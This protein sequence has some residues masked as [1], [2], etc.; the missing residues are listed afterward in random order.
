MPGWI[1]RR[2]ALALL[3]ALLAIVVLLSSGIGAVAI[4]AGTV[5]RMI[6][7]RVLTWLGFGGLPGEW[8]KSY[9]A[10]VFQ[11]RLPRI[12]L[13]VLSGWALALAGT[14]FQ[15]LFKNPMADPYLIGIS[16]GAAVGAAFAI[17]LRVGLGG[18][19]LGLG[20]VPPLAFLGALG[21]SFLVYWLARVGGR[22]SLTS[23]LL[24][25]V[26]VSAFLTAVVSLVMV[27]GTKDMQQVIFWLMGSF[28]GRS[29]QHVWVI[30]P[31]IALG[32]GVML[33]F[34]RELNVA[35][36]GEESAQYLGVDVERMKKILIASGSLVAAAAVSVSG[37]IGFVGLIVP[38]AVRLIVGPDHRVL[39][40]AAGIV[41]AIFLVLADT[42]ARTAIAPAEL[43]VGIVTA[44][45][46]AP[47]F[48][49]LLTKA[50]GRTR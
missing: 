13:A 29:W 49:Y 48:M 30:V 19:A 6:S 3:L 38:H 26:A 2:S 8:P 28:S 50:R 42:L 22:L 25:G 35:L 21:T 5:A 40:P 16:S 32:S 24:G 17:V 9:E 39:M 23:L 1:R 27:L 18:S 7:N 12:L 45:S 31:Y 10:I 46:G 37:I 34:A 47:F 15:G 36:T 20:A 44:L 11:V 41:G 33:P 4:P 14:V 43:P